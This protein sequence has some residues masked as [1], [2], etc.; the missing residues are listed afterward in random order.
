[1]TSPLLF[2]TFV[3][4]SLI[5]ICP[6]Q[7][8][9]SNKPIIVWYFSINSI[10][11]G[12]Y[13][14]VHRFL[15]RPLWNTLLRLGVNHTSIFV[16]IVYCVIITQITWPAAVCAIPRILTKLIFWVPCVCSIDALR[17]QF[18][19]AKTAQKLISEN[20]SVSIN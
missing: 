3:L 7:I 9:F 20:V 6:N 8:V 11:V 15:E 16:C 14:M 13:L 1:M 18:V 2:H 10:D 17:N 12:N 4:S 5:F 19:F